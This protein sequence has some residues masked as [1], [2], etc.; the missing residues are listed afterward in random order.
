M[1][2]RVATLMGAHLKVK[3]QGLPEKLRRGG[4]M[5]PR[6]VRTQAA[7][8]ADAVK[9]AE[10]PHLRVR[11]D[12]GRITEAYDACVRHLTKINRWERRRVAVLNF[13]AS[14]TFNLLVLAALVIVVLIWRGYL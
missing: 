14:V 9:Q 5:L 2:D 4:H 7:F 8:L 3:G 12:M 1:A 13:L 6:R 11:L 10:N